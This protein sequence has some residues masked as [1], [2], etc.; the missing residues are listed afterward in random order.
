MIKLVWF[1][2]PWSCSQK[3]FLFPSSI[4]LICSLLQPAV[5]GF[6]A[7]FWTFYVPKKMRG[8]IEIKS[9]RG[10]GRGVYPFIL[11]F[12]LFFQKWFPAFFLFLLLFISLYVRSRS[13]RANMAVSTSRAMR[14]DMSLLDICSSLFVVVEL[15]YRRK[16]TASSRFNSAVDP[17]DIRNSLTSPLSFS[18]VLRFFGVPLKCLSS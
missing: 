17:W 6:V 1:S 15:K 14:D 3:T 7:W 11:W 12:F 2:C 4:V 13:L 8:P 18:I 16:V 9:F 5:Q 10:S